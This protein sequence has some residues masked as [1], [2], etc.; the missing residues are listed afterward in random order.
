MRRT[1][2]LDAVG[3]LG[4]HD[5][6]CWV[7]TTSGEFR[8]A[9]GRFLTDGLAEGLRVMYIADAPGDHELDAVDGFA[10]ARASGAA[11]VLDLRMYGSG[12]V[13]PVAQ[14]EAY[15]AA[16]EQALADGYTGLRVAADA[17]ALVRTPDGRDAF[18]RY[19]HLV[20]A[21][22]TRHPFSAMCGYDLDDLGPAAVAELAC[23]HPLARRS[24]TALRLHAT[25]EPGIAAVL[26]GE[27]DVLGHA[28][29]R[30]A[31]NRVELADT[32]GEV[33]IDGRDLAF[34]DH[35][36]LIQV[37]EHIRGQGATT[38]LHVGPR[39]M[40]RPLAGLLRLPDLRVAVS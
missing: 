19:E 40:A 35:R 15:A 25:D 21:Y 6:V 13:D 38:V 37:V 31:L 33:A 30:G 24:S 17:T 5:H 36:G 26:A 9:A 23:M 16:T 1:G 32:D 20:D 22:M 4:R 28:Q 7:F 34:I 10:S 11:Q 2:F 18:A 39:S 14:V 8:S 12:V 27:V 3:G 29:L